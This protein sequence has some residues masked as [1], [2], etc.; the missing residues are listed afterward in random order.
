MNAMDL[1]GMMIESGQVE[2][3]G[4]GRRE[5]SICAGTNTAKTGA[6]FNGYGAVPSRVCDVGTLG[7]GAVAMLLGRLDQHADR[8][9]YKG[10]VQVAAS[11]ESSVP[12]GVDFMQTDTK[13]LLAEGVKLALKTYTLSRC[14]RVGHQIA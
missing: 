14:L 8:P 1:A 7:S 10:S 2:R 5:Q 6:R 12:P 4:R 13:T 9:S 11:E 3:V